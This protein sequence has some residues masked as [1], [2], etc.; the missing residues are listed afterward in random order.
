MRN[1]ALA[2]ADPARSIVLMIE[3]VARGA[4][5]PYHKR[6]LVL[7]YAV[8]RH[9]AE[10]LR[11][12][13]WR[14]D[15]RAEQPDF[16]QAFAAHV[17]VSAPSRL[18]IEEQSEWGMT[19]R[20]CA[21]AHEH[22]LPVDVTPP[23]NVVSE[24]EDYDRLLRG[25]GA[26]VTM[27]T[28]YRAMRVKTGVL[29]DGAEP[30]GGRWNFDRENRSPPPKT[31]LRFAPRATF[32]PD[33]I[34]RGAI[35]TVETHFGDHPGDIGDWDLPVTRTDALAMLDDF[36]ERRLDTFG[37]WQDAMVAGERAMSHSLLSAA[38]NVGLLH[39]LEVVERAELAFRS[40]RARLASVEGFVRQV[41]GWR[42][43][44]W[45]TYRCWMPEYKERNALGA[46]LPLP[47][48]YRDGQTRMFCMREAVSHVR[49]TAYAH[50]ILR[51]MVL[52]N[53]ALI[54]GVVPRE[55][56][57]WFH[58]MFVDGY[59]W[60]MAPNA[61]GMALHADGG[62][63]GTKPYAA[64]ANYIAKMSNYCGRCRYDPK[65]A[66][67]EDACPF[68]ALY[69]DFIA[70]NERRF[71]ANHRMRVIVRAW[72]GRPAAWRVA[73]RERARLLRERMRAGAPV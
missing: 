59:D 32:P 64:S 47:A 34:T 29:M 12:A 10:D 68:N 7:I 51:L 25:D 45:R 5:L 71:A 38:I 13:G 69:W 33:A 63:V 26:R 43:F 18:R 21:L 11:A 53:F 31:G 6:K 39:P 30:A 37:P 44:V 16:A 27:E 4:M 49:E 41:L 19:E 40:G 8:M 22:G 14:V 15:Y 9:F 65:Q 35:A 24:P 52:G 54:A 36:C 66:T 56:H 2:G 57:D 72:A 28:F 46:D 58:A 48:F 42:E 1:S 50:H 3:S 17:A 70:R 55:A 60:V 67:G 23:S 73:V 62:L 20:L 61:I